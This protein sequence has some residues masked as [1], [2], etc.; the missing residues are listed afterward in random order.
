MNEQPTSQAGVLTGPKLRWFRRFWFVF[1]WMATIVLLSKVELLIA[2]V[3]AAIFLIVVWTGEVGRFRGGVMP[4]G[5]KAFMSA[6]LVLLLGWGWINVAQAQTLPLD[7]NDFPICDSVEM[8]QAVKQ[9]LNSGPA[10]QMQG[11]KALEVLNGMTAAENAVPRRNDETAA[12]VRIR[13]QMNEMMRGV[14]VYQVLTNEGARSM[15]ANFRWID[16]ARGRYF[17]EVR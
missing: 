3:L 13:E 14:C 10:A 9:T 11:F 16:R 1:I 17:I 2:S 15:S 12:D 8:K 6:M 7:E 4:H 5:H